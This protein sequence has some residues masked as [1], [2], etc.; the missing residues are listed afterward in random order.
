MQRPQTRTAIIRFLKAVRIEEWI[1]IAAA[2]ACSVVLLFIPYSHPL[3]PLSVLSLMLRY[4]TFGNPFYIVFFVFIWGVVVWKLYLFIGHAAEDLLEHRRRDGREIVRRF[5]RVLAPLRIALPIIIIT[6]PLYRLLTVASYNLRFSGKDLSLY[7]ADIALFGKPLF[8][9]L[10]SLHLGSL[11]EH[12]VY[13]SY[14][15]LALVLGSVLVVLILLKK[16]VWVRRSVLAFLLSSVIAF[17][18]FFM[19]P[20]QDPNN[21]FIRNVRHTEIPQ[22]VRTALGAYHPSSFTTARI[23]QIQNAETDVSM[24]NT[25]PIS[26]FP[27]AHAMWAIFSVYYLAVIL[28]WTLIVSVPWA[29]LLL[30]GGLYFAQHYAVDYLIAAVIAFVCIVAA[31]RMI[32]DDAKKGGPQLPDRS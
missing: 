12:I 10:P 16:T 24:D 9:W 32:R 17:P 7:A 4:F 11:F 25:V 14:I 31:N 1:A 22:E 28:P 30:T 19:V 13:D 26:C 29:L 15:S 18:I 20:C 21:A 5:L 23:L 8:F 6:I 27:S 2:A 3:S